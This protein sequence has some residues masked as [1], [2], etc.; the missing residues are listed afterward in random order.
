M[1]D[2]TFDYGPR[3]RVVVVR[4]PAELARETVDLALTTVIAAQAERRWAYTALSGGSTPKAMGEVLARQPYRD[5]IAWH[6]LHVFW[7]DERWVPLSS[8]ESNAGE[9]KRIFLDYVPIPASQVHPYETEGMTPEE[10]AARYAELVRS[11]VPSDGGLPRFDLIFLGMGDDGHTASLFPHTAPIHEQDQ[12]VVSHV[13][14]KLE[15][16]RLTFTPPLLNAARLVIFLVGGAGKAQRLKEVLEGPEQPDEL[17]SQVVRPVDG[18]LIWLVDR[19]AASAL[20][21]A[22]DLPRG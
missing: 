20:E 18:E 15:S 13:V 21:I 4:D 12:L 2:A 22:S 16:P 9:A 5:L 17:P 8:P 19:A 11:L 6:Y 10:S 3:G 1:I 7:G 14:P